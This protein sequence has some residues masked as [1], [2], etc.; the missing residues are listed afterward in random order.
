MKQWTVEFPKAKVVE[1]L[2]GVQ[3]L[4]GEQNKEGYINKKKTEER[5]RRA[6]LFPE[7]ASQ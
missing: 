5:A 6:K 4:S 1:G 2:M 3:V 7:R